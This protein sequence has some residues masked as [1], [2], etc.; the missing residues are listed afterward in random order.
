MQPLRWHQKQNR[1]TNKLEEAKPGTK[2][3]RAKRLKDVGELRLQVFLGACSVR[4]RENGC[5]GERMA[6]NIPRILFEGKDVSVA[7]TTHVTVNFGTPSRPGAINGFCR[8]LGS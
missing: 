2:F 6:A 8:G 3:L 5:L 4:K 1:R 7:K